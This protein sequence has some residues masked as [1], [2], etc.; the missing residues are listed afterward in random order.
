MTP[1]IT[2]RI[3]ILEAWLRLRG[4]R[5]LDP[6]GATVERVRSTVVSVFAERGASRAPEAAPE[7]APVAARTARR[8]WGSGR[9]TIV[10]SAGRRDR[11]SERVLPRRARP[12][13][14]AAFAAALT[15]VSVGGPAWVFA[16]ES[17]P[18]HALYDVRVAVETIGLPR[19]GTADRAIAETARLERRLAEVREEWRA[20][21]WTGAEAALRATGDEATAL[22]RAL[23]AAPS[24]RTAVRDRIREVRHVLRAASADADAPAAVR[25]AAQRTEKAL[26]QA[27]I[28]PARSPGVRRPRP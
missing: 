2:D 26:E 20:R 28:S 17:S 24:A 18:G 7:A 14:A 25:S 6:D 22:E 1:G 21:D 8:E 9:A 5:D 16:S 15:A 12:F 27:G 4:R 3:E 13:V 11:I 19:I 23:A 10:D